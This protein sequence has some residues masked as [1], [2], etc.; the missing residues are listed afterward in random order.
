MGQVL[1]FQPKILPSCWSP[2]P[3]EFYRCRREVS[4][5][6]YLHGPGNGFYAGHFDLHTW[7][8]RWLF[9]EFTWD[10]V[11]KDF[12]VWVVEASFHAQIADTVVEGKTLAEWVRCM[13]PMQFVQMCLAHGVAA[14][15]VLERIQKKADLYF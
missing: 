10:E 13:R 4:G 1:V 11:P 12:N 14:P 7:N 3:P 6:V 9:S 5:K 15:K 2:K 8:L